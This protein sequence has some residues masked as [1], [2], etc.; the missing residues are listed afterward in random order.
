[1]NA[2]HQQPAIA[3]V[4]GTSRWYYSLTVVL[5]AQFFGIAA[6]LGT[7]LTLGYYAPSWEFWWYGWRTKQIIAKQRKEQKV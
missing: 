4:Y 3:K 6:A 2:I 5:P 1:M 7:I